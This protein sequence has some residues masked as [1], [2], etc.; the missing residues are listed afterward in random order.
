MGG[1][2]RKVGRCSAVAAELWGVHTGLDLA[3]ELQIQCVEVESDSSIMVTLLNK[4]Q[5][6]APEDS[7]ILILHPLD[8]W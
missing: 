6:E 3:I 2:A 1:F 5:E 7:N 4:M 8:V